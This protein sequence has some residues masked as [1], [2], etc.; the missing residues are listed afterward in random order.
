[1]KHNTS[2]YMRAEPLLNYPAIA[3]ELRLPERYVRY[4]VSKGVIPYIRLGH[5]TI[6]FRLSDVE[7]ALK[8]REVKEEP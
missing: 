8:K 2:G 5:K 6:R 4:L 3:G 7:R 1:M